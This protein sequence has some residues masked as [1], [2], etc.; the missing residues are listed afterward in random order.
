MSTYPKTNDQTGISSIQL[1]QNTVADEANSIDSEMIGRGSVGSD[2]LN[3]SVIYCARNFSVNEQIESQNIFRYR[4]FPET[5]AGPH[6]SVTPVN[7]DPIVDEHTSIWHR[8]ERREWGVLDSHSSG[9][10]ADL[11]NPDI[12]ETIT[13]DD[14]IGS[15]DFDSD[16]RFKHPFKSK[17]FKIPNRG[18]GYNLLFHTDINLSF[19]TGNRGGP[20]TKWIRWFGGQRIWTSVIYALKPNINSK[21]VLCWS[22]GHMIGA[23]ASISFDKNDNFPSI[24]KTHSYTDVI[25][26]NDTFIRRLCDAQGIDFVDKKMEL[27]GT[28]SFGWAVTACLDR[29]DEVD[30]HTD[31]KYA[32]GGS[33][34][35]SFA[36]KQLTGLAQ[37][38]RIQVVGGNT[39]F[40]AFKDIDNGADSLTNYG[41]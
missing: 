20:D 19:A 3:D 28:S 5:I 29:W 2:V 36:S 21:R 34:S 1:M 33:F 15:A 9:T 12:V 37:G 38:Q 16:L 39:N 14:W 41:S 40:I 24:Q 7:T 6:W 18:R 13:T 8:Q 23:S 27:D 4:P 11:A 17:M 35:A 22:P 26:V 32:F 30:P 31:D 25:S 10:L